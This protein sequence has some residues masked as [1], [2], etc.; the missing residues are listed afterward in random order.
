ME[1]PTPEKS[2][3]KWPVR[4]AVLFC[5]L[6]AL[7][8][9]LGSFFFWTLLGLSAYFV[10]L[11][12]YS[13]DAKISWFNRRSTSESPYPAYRRSSRKT[14]PQDQLSLGRKIIR[15]LVIGFG[16]MLVLLFIAGIFAKQNTDP[17]S[18]STGTNSSEP[19]AT[20]E[21]TDYVGRGNDF[22]DKTQYDSALINYDKALAIDPE[23]QYA[24]YNKALVFYM[25]K[26]YR[27][28]IG[29]VKKCLRLYP[30]YDTGWWL[31]GDDY[32]SL[33]NN[34]SAAICLDKAYSHGYSDPGFLQLMGDVY[35][36]KNDRVKA[37]EL[38]LKVITQD[39][40]KAEVYRQLA[41]LDPENADLY[42]KKARALEQV[43]Q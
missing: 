13:S 30:D 1:A 26:D 28:S 23:N 21:D 22:F 18:E 2:K 7:F 43:P 8:W 14:P 33:N 17:S 31:M 10:F 15:A 37:R 25:K 5:F 34:D 3:N 40:S 12:F 20:N 32:S 42:R 24:L 38:F 4:L 6:F 41:D 16:G 27:R 39:S 29:L 11:A 9:S 36:K 19:A 35:L